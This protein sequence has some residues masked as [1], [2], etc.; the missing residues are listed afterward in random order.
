[1]TLK[2]I[3]IEANQLTEFACNSDNYYDDICP[4]IESALIRVHNEAIEAAA[5][6]SKEEKG[7]ITKYKEDYGSAVSWWHLACNVITEQ[8]VQLKLPTPTSE[9]D[10]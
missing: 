8:L 5:K 10:K 7:Y 2:E 9:Q 4:L 3:K 6:I 1:M